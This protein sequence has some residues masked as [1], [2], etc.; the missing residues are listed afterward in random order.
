MRLKQAK[1]CCT[2]NNRACQYRGICIRAERQITRRIVKTD[3]VVFPFCEEDEVEEDIAVVL[4]VTVLLL[5]QKHN[6]RKNLS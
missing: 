2:F 4:L 1:S 3:N 6:G 5:L